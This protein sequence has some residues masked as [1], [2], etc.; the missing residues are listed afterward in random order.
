MEEVVEAP[1]GVEK[2]SKMAPAEA[3]KEYDDNTHATP[4]RHPVMFLILIK[5]PIMFPI[6][7]KGT[8]FKGIRAGVLATGQ[9]YSNSKHLAAV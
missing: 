3:Q 8:R 1:G 9:Y 2:Y 7:K 4:A 5:Q 6:L